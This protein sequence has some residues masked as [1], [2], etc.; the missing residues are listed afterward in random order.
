MTLG[1]GTE[2]R[3]DSASSERL[4]NEDV[5]K[6]RWIR[7]PV[8]VRMTH[9]LGPV[10]GDEVLPARLCETVQWQP[11]RHDRHFLDL[12]RADYKHALTHT[13]PSVGAE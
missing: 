13:Y 1:G 8:E 2:R 3:A 11:F 7:T 10:P 6:L 5:L 12:Q 9:W 4:V